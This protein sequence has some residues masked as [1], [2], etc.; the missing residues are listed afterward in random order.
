MI[1]WPGGR[2]GTAMDPLQLLGMVLDLTDAVLGVVGFV[3]FWYL[4]VIPAKQD[5]GPVGSPSS[6][7][8]EI[9]RFLEEV[10]SGTGSGAGHGH[11]QRKQHVTRVPPRLRQL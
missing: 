9:D 10:R 6:G 8:T 11:E 4:W 3:S 2:D 1:F 7:P 5:P